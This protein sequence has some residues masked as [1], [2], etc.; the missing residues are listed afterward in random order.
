MYSPVTALDVAFSAPECYV[1]HLNSDS[2]I[3]VRNRL[4]KALFDK[5]TGYY[6]FDSIDVFGDPET[7]LDLLKEYGVRDA[8]I[9]TWQE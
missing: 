2:L 9:I 7:A 1:H 6:P 5:L 3:T 4:G 8:R